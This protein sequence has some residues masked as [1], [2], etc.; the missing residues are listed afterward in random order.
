VAAI[1]DKTEGASSRSSIAR[2]SRSKQIQQQ[3][4][5]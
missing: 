5:P 1:L 2:S 3:E 4:T